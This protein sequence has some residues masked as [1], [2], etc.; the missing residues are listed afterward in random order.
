MKNTS[1]FSLP[2]PEFGLLVPRSAL[3]DIATLCADLTTRM[4]HSLIREQLRVTR[5]L[6]SMTFEDICPKERA[7]VE[8]YAAQASGLAAEGRRLIERAAEL[9][10]SRGSEGNAPDECWDDLRPILGSPSNVHSL[11]ND[12]LHKDRTRGHFPRFAE[13]RDQ[14][15]AIGYTAADDLGVRPE[16]AFLAGALHLGF[17]RFEDA[18]LDDELDLRY[19]LVED[20]RTRYLGLLLG[21]RVRV[22]DVL[23]ELAGNIWIL[24]GP[25]AL[26]HRAEQAGNRVA[27]QLA[28]LRLF[29][30]GIAELMQRLLVP[31]AP[32]RPPNAARAPPEP[33]TPQLVNLV[34]AVLTAAPPRSGVGAAVLSL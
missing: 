14:A 22:T 20:P 27:D 26:Y 21:N 2:V 15:L 30:A 1:Q 31:Q 3:P 4:Q 28:T 19:R 8:A 9:S 33:R 7:F 34:R 17:S 16:K 23:V 25:R 24:A 5:W 10:Q 13:L 12:R 6:R 18:L 11:L 32:E 29:L